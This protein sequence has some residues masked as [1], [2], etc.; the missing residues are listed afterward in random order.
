MTSM[1]KAIFKDTCILPETPKKHISMSIFSDAHIDIFQ[2][3]QKSV[4]DQKH[5]PYIESL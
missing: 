4:F 5:V 3:I 2:F 1:K